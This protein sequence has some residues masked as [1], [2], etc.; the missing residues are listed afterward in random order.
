MGNGS[1]QRGAEPDTEVRLMM[2]RTRYARILEE[3]R[4]NLDSGADVET[5]LL[6]LKEKGFWQIDCIRALFELG[7]CSS[8][9]AKRVVHFSEAWKDSRAGN[10]RIQAVAEEAIRES[11]E[12]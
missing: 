12:E 4:R 10:A 2:D 6:E 1:S 5:I 11:L 8:S 7:V 3:A 9:D